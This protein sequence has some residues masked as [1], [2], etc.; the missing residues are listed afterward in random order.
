MLYGIR[1]EKNCQEQTSDIKQEKHIKT[2]VVPNGGCEVY[3]TNLIE[4]TKTSN[5]LQNSHMNL[6]YKV[7]KVPFNMERYI[8]PFNIVDTYEE[9]V[10]V[11]NQRKET[12]MNQ[13]ISS[14]TTIEDSQEMGL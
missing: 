12:I 7:F 1:Y 13:V 3:F 2:V 4:A 6:K 11:T 8:K 5:A 10:K 14:E 9:Y